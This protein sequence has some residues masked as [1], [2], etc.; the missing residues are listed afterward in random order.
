MAC[1]GLILM[2][3]SFASCLQ[4]EQPGLQVIQ[5]AP[6]PVQDQT[7]VTQQ[8]TSDNLTPAEKDEQFSP[9]PAV[10][11]VLVHFRG[12]MEPLGCCNNLLYER[13]EYVAVKNFSSV[14]QDIRGWKLTN[15]ARS[16]PVFTFPALFPCIPAYRPELKAEDAIYNSNHTYVENPPDSVIARLSKP[17]VM[18]EPVQG[19]ID[20]SQCGSPDHLDETP[21]KPVAVEA[22]VPAPCILYPGQTV[23][24]FTNEIHCQYG[25]FTFNYGP[26]NIWNNQEPDTAV[27]YNEKGEE[28][29]R[30][31]YY[32][33]R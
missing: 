19:K 7:V 8:A 28:V 31:S 5:P 27:L 12:T 20:W 13:D 26:G 1:T 22:S 29:S 11:I 4:P 32:P 18:V 30:R 3:A 16:Y 2:A 24:V 17:V 15:L 33:G 21:M 10:R 25:G 23:L 9:G 6:Q 14:P